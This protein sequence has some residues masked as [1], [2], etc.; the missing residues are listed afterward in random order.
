[1]GHRLDGHDRLG[2][3]ALALVVALDL[4]VVAHR[5]VGRLDVGPGKILVAVLA[6]AFT[7]LLAVADPFAAHAATIGGVVAHLGK[8]LNRAGLEHDGQPQGLG[9]ALPDMGTPTFLL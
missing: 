4:R 2:A 5:E 3:G 1:M 9:V 7:L 8:A 6:V